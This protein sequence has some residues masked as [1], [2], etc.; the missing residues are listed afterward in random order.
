MN[1]DFK[2]I[3]G[4]LILGIGAFAFILSISNNDLNIA[5][6]YLTA[7][8]IV[9][10]LYGLLL[11]LFDVRAFSWIISV[12]GCLVAI[13]VFF[14]FGIE[15][16][17]YPAGAIV[18]HSGG[19]AGALGIALFALFPILFLYQMGAINVQAKPYVKQDFPV[20]YPEPE[21]VSEEWEM[22]SD[23]DLQSGEFETE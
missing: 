13:A 11:N 18:F 9:W 7:T 8:L 12:S 20:I 17:P 5:L 22:A 14:M 23:D 16:V 19:I 15:E 4:G 10:V 3:V 6:I 1:M 21:I 2:K